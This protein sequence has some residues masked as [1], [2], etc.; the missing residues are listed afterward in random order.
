MAQT[1]RGRFRQTA[2]PSPIDVDTKPYVF[3][4]GVGREFTAQAD[5]WTIKAGVEV[6]SNS[7]RP[8]DCNAA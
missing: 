7:P 5:A 1:A 3:N 2:Y 8:G 6:H 4:F